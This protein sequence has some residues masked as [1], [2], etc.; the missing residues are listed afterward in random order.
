MRDE[1]KQKTRMGRQPSLSKETKEAKKKRE[2]RVSGKSFEGGFSSSDNISDS[3][4][5]M[6]PRNVMQV[7]ELEDGTN[8]PHFGAPP[9]SRDQSN[10]KSKSKSTGLKD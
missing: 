8:E 9:T 5:F 7:P 2:D 1:Y 10:S 3:S 6:D 4:S